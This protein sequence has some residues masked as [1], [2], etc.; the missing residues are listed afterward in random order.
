MDAVITRWT[1]KPQSTET[2]G[3]SCF[4]CG[5]YFCTL[6]KWHDGP[7]LC[8]KCRKEWGA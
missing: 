1:D 7:C 2:C 5:Y 4:D 3:L 6:V 8:D